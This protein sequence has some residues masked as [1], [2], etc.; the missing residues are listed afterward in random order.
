MCKQ[1]LIG[2]TMIKKY[3]LRFMFVLGLLSLAACETTAPNKKVD[4]DTETVT[5]SQVILDD[6]ASDNTEQDVTE[7]TE[8]QDDKLDATEGIN[9]QS[10]EAT[11]DE[12][13]AAAQNQGAL[14]AILLADV[15]P[16][17]GWNQVDIGNGMLYFHPEPILDRDDFKGVSATNNNGVGMVV[18]EM[19]EEG[20]KHLLAKTTDNP[21]MLLAFVIDTTLLSMIGY[22]Q[23]V[24][25]DFL[26]FSAGNTE[27]AVAVAQAIAG[28]SNDNQD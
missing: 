4:E 18:L 2:K 20:Q 8:L 12:N 19:N 28:V 13:A 14:F 3:I 9:A 16:H 7:N 5:T 15:N 24:D 17:A 26:A 1:S 22:S 10:A 23:P 6:N 21:D 11:T 27:N 25:S